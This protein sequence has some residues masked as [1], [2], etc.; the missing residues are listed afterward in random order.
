MIRHAVPQGIVPGSLQHYLTR[1]YPLLNVRALLKKR[2]VKVNGLR[3]E[4][5]FPL[6]PGDEA[7]G[8][9]RAWLW[10]PL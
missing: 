10:K 5:E 2:D 3:R 6:R 8:R 7:R 4:G 1:A 9:D